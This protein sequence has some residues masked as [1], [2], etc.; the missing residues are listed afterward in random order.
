MGHLYRLFYVRSQQH[1]ECSPQTLVF[2]RNLRNP[3]AEIWKTGEP[4]K[5]KSGKDMLTSLADLR[6]QLAAAAD[7]AKTE[8]LYQTKRQKAIYDRKSR[9]RE[10]N[11]GD[12]VLV[13]QPISTLNSSPNGMDHGS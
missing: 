2:G 5:P 7:A 11:V 13:L 9:K 10:L 8:A 4:E 12:R 1:T 6:T 3:L